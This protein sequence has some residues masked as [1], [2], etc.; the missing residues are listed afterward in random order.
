MKFSAGDVVSYLTHGVCRIENIVMKVAMVSEVENEYYELKPASSPK[1]TILIPT[2]NKELTAKMKRVLTADEIEAL[3][4]DKSAALVLADNKFERQAQYRVVFED[5]N[6]ADLVKLIKALGAYQE[7]V[8]DEGKKVPA[9]D[10]DALRK[11]GQTLQEEFS[12][13]LG[14]KKEEVIRFV[15]G[16]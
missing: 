6:R 5:G 16:G 11:A 2:R 9:I 12:F 7:E 3:I 13:V 8:E 15:V 14:I 1:S 4:K 10:R